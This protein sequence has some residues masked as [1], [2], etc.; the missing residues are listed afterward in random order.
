M[1]D[2]TQNP[3]T[4]AP[5]PNYVD[6]TADIVAAYVVKNAVQRADLTMAQVGNRAFSVESGWQRG[7]GTAERGI[8]P[9]SADY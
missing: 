4:G 2:A 8:T 9:G 3:S 1:A 6:L 5:Q 7:G